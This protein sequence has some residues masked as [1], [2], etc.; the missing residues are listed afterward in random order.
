METTYS[1]KWK[2]SESGERLVKISKDNISARIRS[3]SK[4][5]WFYGDNFFTKKE[6][7]KS[8]E[9]LVKISRDNIPFGRRPCI[10]SNSFYWGESAWKVKGDSREIVVKISWDYKLPNE[11]PVIVRKRR[12]S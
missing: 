11:D 9:R 8:G 7:S 6:K 10:K 1:R 2:K 4:A 5:D 12:W 3:W